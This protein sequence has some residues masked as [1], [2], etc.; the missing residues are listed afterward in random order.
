MLESI[1]KWLARKQIAKFEAAWNYDMS[2]ARDMMEASF[3]SF[4]GFAGI[5]KLA[6]AKGVTPAPAMYAVKIATTMAED[7]ARSWW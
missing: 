2:Y 6:G 7:C 1:G 3:P 5:I 4:R